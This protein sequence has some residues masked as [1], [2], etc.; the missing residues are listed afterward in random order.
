MV[1]R[2]WKVKDLAKVMR[3]LRTFRSQQSGKHRYSPSLNVNPRRG[4][5]KGLSQTTQL[6]AGR[7][8]V[9]AGLCDYRARQ[10]TAEADV[11][12]PPSLLAHVV[13]LKEPPQEVPTTAG[14]CGRLR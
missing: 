2:A 13:R 12:L 5:H 9:S 7:A 14:P 4:G 10:L 8:A 11:S 1:P 3:E 6:L